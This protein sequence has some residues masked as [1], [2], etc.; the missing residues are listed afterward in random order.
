MG[1]S[2]IIFGR[3]GRRIFLDAD[4]KE[5]KRRL[6]E[7]FIRKIWKAALE[8]IGEEIT[9]MYIDDFL[10]YFIRKN[11]FLFSLIF[12][13]QWAGQRLLL[14]YIK[15]LIDQKFKEFDER[16]IVKLGR[17]LSHR[18]LK[19]RLPDIRKLLNI[20]NKIVDVLSKEEIIKYSIELYSKDISRRLEYSSLFKPYR[21][22]NFKDGLKRAIAASYYGDL[23]EAYR[24]LLGALEFKADN[25]AALFAA[26]IA[27][28][29]RR[30]PP[31]YPA[32]QIDAVKKV[33][34]MVKPKR[35]HEKILLDY[36]NTLIKAER[37]YEAF[38]NIKKFLR[39]HINE[40]FKAFKE[41]EDV[42]HTD[43]L[44]YILT[45]AD[46]TVLSR[47]K[48]D[49][50]HQ[51]LGNRSMILG[52]YL[53]SA[54]SRLRS[55]SLLTARELYIKDLS[56]Y[57]RLLRSKYLNARVD[58]LKIIDRGIEYYDRVARETLITYV[59]MLVEYLRGVYFSFSIR[60]VNYD[61]VESFIKE[62][63]REAMEGLKIVTDKP[64]PIPLDAIFEA[65]QLLG[66]ILH[67]AETFLDATIFE[68]ITRGFLTV[69]QSFYL[70]LSSALAHGRLSSE[71]ITR[72]PVL[73]MLSSMYMAKIGEF[74]P[75]TVCLVKDILKVLNKHKKELIRV[76][77]E[78]LALVVISLLVSIVCLIT[79]MP[80]DTQRKFAAMIKSILMHIVEWSMSKTL[81]SVPLW[82]MLIDSLR[83]LIITAENMRE[84][85]YTIIRDLS[86]AVVREDIG[87]I[88]EAMLMS[89]LREVS[90]R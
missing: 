7:E 85:Y 80:E 72:L 82:T 6:S 51:Y 87:A 88:R 29:L 50:L 13:S 30:L 31:Q 55:F 79:F 41:L 49:F 32:P 16:S 25:I 75:F 18:F 22:V 90:K 24:L 56:G 53:R 74:Q 45:T 63:L 62:V 1:K 19:P 12:D 3:D 43:I 23:L 33:M 84:D 14:G 60:E 69:C 2:I 89:I 4:T 10:V 11:E 81:I 71:W 38:L 20:L 5:L 70:L 68:E 35:L 76:N 8:E 64:P 83:T 52:A 39:R 42:Y 59:T 67:Y 27:M 34:S 26:Y 46:P 66:L 73:L 17:E 15:S 57:L 47:V 9:E 61:D 40:L 37:S 77:A 86:R 78:S 21:V 58:A 44:A 54:L 36:I 65:I 48:I 28:Q